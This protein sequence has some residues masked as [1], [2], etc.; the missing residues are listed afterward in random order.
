MQSNNLNLVFVFLISFVEFYFRFLLLFF[1][2]CR[3][4][5]ALER[6]AYYATIA[7]AHESRA[8]QRR[9]RQIVRHSIR[10]IQIFE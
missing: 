9:A 6:I 4:A 8:P 3:R 10:L 1:Q 5:A 2:S 7:R